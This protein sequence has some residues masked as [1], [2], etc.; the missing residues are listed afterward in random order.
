M[1]LGPPARG[2]AEALRIETNSSPIVVF[3]H[4]YRLLLNPVHTI[5]RNKSHSSPTLKTANGITRAHR[6]RRYQYRPSKRTRPM[7]SI[8]FSEAYSNRN[9]ISQKMLDE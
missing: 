9:E 8:S 5:T 7:R 1:P 4:S 2:S 3:G 6:V